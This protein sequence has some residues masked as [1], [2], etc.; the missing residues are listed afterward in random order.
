MKLSAEFLRFNRGIRNNDRF[1]KIQT[2]HLRKT[3]L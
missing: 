2:F 1:E 3:V